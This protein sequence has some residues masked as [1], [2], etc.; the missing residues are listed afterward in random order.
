M[1]TRNLG[2]T[3][4]KVAIFSLGGE[5]ALDK[6]DNHDVAIPIIERAIDLGVNYL[7]TAPWY[8]RPERWSQRYIGE[9]MKNRRDEV[10]LATKTHDRT[11]DGSMRLLEESLQLLQTD[12]V[13]AWQ[14]HRLSYPKDND[15]VF[16]K[17]GAMKALIEAREQGVVRNLGITGHTD[18]DV[19]MEAMRRF[20]FDQILMA[21]NAADPHH[22]S[23]TA[24][25]LPMAVEQ[26]MGIIGMKVC[27][28]GRILDK[29]TMREA[30]NY[31]LSYPVSTVVV[32]C[33]DIPQLEENI[34]LARSFT[35]IS[36]RQMAD[37]HERTESIAS[38]SLW[39]RR[40]A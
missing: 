40:D 16:A 9:V 10:Y 2:R 21:F 32:G 25:L 35:P 24:E 17:D 39:F 38:R 19:L 22:L 6:P 15:E 4:H 34:E 23:F 36:E 12:H 14:L 31:V 37:L 26:E 33:D 3:G 30:M 28:R 1:P 8:G 29:I 18:P 5:S 11:Y 7:D 27:A 13:D 20:D